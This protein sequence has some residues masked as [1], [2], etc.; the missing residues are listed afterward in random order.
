MYSTLLSVALFSALA[1]QGALAEFTVN[2][3]E[4]KQ[5]ESVHLTWDD[6]GAE[7]YNVIIVPDSDPCNSVLVDLG[8]HDMNHI[9]WNNVT[10]DVGTKLMVS[11]LDAKDEEGWS[12]VVAVKAGNNTACLPNASSSAPASSST[13]ASSAAAS[14]T[15]LVVNPAVAPTGASSA[16]AA[17]TT[18]GASAVG[19]ANEGILGNNN[20]ALSSVKISGSALLLTLGAVA[21]VAF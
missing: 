12:G 7:S 1:V 8:D 10:L 11:V 6:T 14:G 19:A 5:C 13:K 2:T 20:G 4:V 9:S 21:A 18:S 16:P 17:P 15:T 3:P